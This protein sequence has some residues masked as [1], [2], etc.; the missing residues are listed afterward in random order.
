MKYC[1]PFLCLCFIL[2]TSGC[3][4]VTK[5]DI[6]NSQLLWYKEAAAVWEEALPLGNGRIGAMVFG[7]P[8]TERI[9]LNDDSLWPKD[10]LW[11]TYQSI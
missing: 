11:G 6:T 7:D 10:L 5:P 1:I 9:Q 3:N 8:H 4:N 2:I